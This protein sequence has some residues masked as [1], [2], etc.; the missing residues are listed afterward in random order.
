VAQLERRR[1]GCRQMVLMMGMLRKVM[2]H[3]LLGKVVKVPQ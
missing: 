2:V 1:V 3:L